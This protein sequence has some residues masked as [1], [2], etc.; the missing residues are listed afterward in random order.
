MFF[1]KNTELVIEDEVF[2]KT[3]SLKYYN[4]S[5]KVLKMKRVFV[6]PRLEVLGDSNHPQSI[7]NLET[8]KAAG[9]PPNY[10][11]EGGLHYL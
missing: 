2:D 4:K 8:I 10:Q 5:R 7:P 6:K 11:K 3:P 9:V 1:D